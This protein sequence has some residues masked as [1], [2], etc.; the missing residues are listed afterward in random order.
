[1]ASAWEFDPPK[2]VKE[3]SETLL[4]QVPKEYM[5]VAKYFEVN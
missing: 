3:A 4:E 2:K 5:L 1:M